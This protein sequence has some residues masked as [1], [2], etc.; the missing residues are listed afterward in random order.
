MKLKIATSPHR[1]IATSPHRYI[2][3][4]DF[5]VLG[6]KQKVICISLTSFDLT[7]GRKT[8]EV[9]RSLLHL[10]IFFAC[11]RKRKALDEDRIVSAVHR[12]SV[13]LCELFNTHYSEVVKFAIEIL[14]D[15]FLGYTVHRPDVPLYHST[16]HA[17]NER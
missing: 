12:I 10:S 11:F 7:S 13:F 6:E 8:S 14:E 9:E 5:C 4:A 16:T 2:R 15:S 1:H 3:Q 17:M